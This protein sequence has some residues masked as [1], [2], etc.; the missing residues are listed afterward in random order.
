MARERG[1]SRGNVLYDLIG[2]KS[3]IRENYNM[4]KEKKELNATLGKKNKLLGIVSETINVEL[5]RL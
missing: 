4:L 3:K 5:N 2:G 1:Q